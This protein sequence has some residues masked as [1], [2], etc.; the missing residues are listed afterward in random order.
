[1]AKRDFVTRK[2]ICPNEHCGNTIYERTYARNE[3]GAFVPVWTCTNC[4]R[5][6]PRNMRNR[7]SNHMRAMDLWRKLRDEWKPVDEKLMALAEA[8]VIKSGAILVY[9]SAYNYHM[10]RLLMESR[11]SN[12]NV[13]YC[14]EQARRQMTEAIKFIEEESKGHMPTSSLS[15]STL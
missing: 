2:T 11:M 14:A 9:G 6:Y 5:E 4:L 13:R 3:Q 7:R 10:D 8:R 15:T 1:M 12:F